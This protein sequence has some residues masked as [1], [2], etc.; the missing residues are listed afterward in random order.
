[1][2][3]NAAVVLLLHSVFVKN[4]DIVLCFSCRE[5]A[6]LKAAFCDLLKLLSGMLACCM[7]NSCFLLHRMKDTF[8]T[9]SSH[10]PAEIP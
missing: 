5:C 1:M 8:N 2:I 4:V 10:I 3:S 7:R 6:S 9:A